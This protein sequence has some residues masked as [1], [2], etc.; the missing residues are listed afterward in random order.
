MDYATVRERVRTGQQPAAGRPPRWTP[1]GPLRDVPG[2]G[3]YFA[4]RLANQTVPGGAAITPAAVARR[5]NS[6]LAGMGRAGRRA[7]LV[8]ILGAVCQNKRANTCAD[9]YHIRDINPGCFMGL[10]AMMSI[11]WGSREVHHEAHQALPQHVVDE[12]G[13][14]TVVWRRNK[15]AAGGVY[16]AAQC[17]CKTTQATC[18]QGPCVWSPAGV[19]LPANG[20]P[21]GFE[22][23]GTYTGQ[24]VT[25]PGAPRRLGAKYTVAPGSGVEWRRPGKLAN[26]RVWD[27]G[28][29]P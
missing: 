19:C 22:G 5:I 15:T 1:D 20:V 11:L 24:R 21:R 28:N 3:A 12:V 27:G 8:R 26:V 4:R 29:W 7:G 17:S 2:I 14:N 13:S 25:Q 6:W 9:G 18:P 16:P 10:A 23:V